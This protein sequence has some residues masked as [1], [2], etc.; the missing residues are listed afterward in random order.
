MRYVIYGAGAVG[1]VI[2]GRL[3]EHGHDV[4]LIARGAHLDALRDRGLELQSP[5]GTVT[6]PVPV[7]AGPHQIELDAGDVV[8]LAMKSQDT[9]AAVEDLGAI[10]DQVPVVCAQN[11][12]ENER[13]ALRRFSA[14]YGMSVFLPATHLAP[15][16]VQANGS[17]MSGILDLGRYPSGTDELAETVARDLDGS[18]FSSRAVDAIMRNKY[19][20]LLLNLGN[21]LEAACGPIGRASE[22]FA[23]AQAE[24]M[25]CFRAAGI[26]VASPEE[27]EQRRSNIMRL[28][29][30]GGQRR[31]GGSS[32][33]SLAR[34]TRRIEADYL[35][36]EVVLL[37]RLHGIDT[38]VNEV[39][40]RVAN[41]LARQE[42]PPESM[43]LEELMAELALAEAA[44]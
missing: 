28:R 24:A 14:V 21:A 31:G 12:V 1:G 8:V 27:A 19:A 9:A 32:W 18:R 5:D 23:R 3:F 36:G 43:S 30:V 4:V 11:G 38:P 40:Q 17:P 34:G 42:R 10:S 41:R 15:G 26:D 16:V 6:L 37:G 44:G 7:A 33:Q 25:S 22:L 35:N 13:V 2:G 20:K 39:L 29:P